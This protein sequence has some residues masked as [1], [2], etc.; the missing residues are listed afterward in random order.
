MKNLTI[1]LVPFEFSFE[2]ITIYYSEGSQEGYDT[3]PKKLLNLDGPDKP[4]ERVYWDLKRFK[5][6]RTA[7]INKENFQIIK[8]ILKK[9][10]REYFLEKK[11]IV[12]SDFIDGIALLEKQNKYSISDLTEYKKFTV[13]IIHPKQ[14]YACNHGSYWNLIISYMGKT[15]ITKKPL[16]HYKDFHDVI[17]KAVVGNTVKHINMLTPE[18]EKS[19]D[20][21]ALVSNKFRIRKTWPK[22]F[23]K[24]PNKYSMFYNEIFAFYENYIKGKEVKINKNDKISIFTS[25][26]QTIRNESIIYTKQDSNLLIF[27]ENRTHFDPYYGIKEHGPH[28]P[29]EQEKYRFF[30]I[31]HQDDRDIA[32]KLYAYF[33]NGIKGFPGLFRFVGLNID[34]FDKEKTIKFKEENPLPEIKQKLESLNFDSSIKYLGIYISRIKKDTDDLDKKGIYYKLKELLLKKNITSQV[35]YRDN[36]MEPSFNYYLPNIGIAVLA[37]FGGIPWRLHRPIESDLI[38]GVGAYRAKQDTYIGT[39]MTFKNDGSFVQFDSSEANSIEDISN[40]LKKI[41]LQISERYENNFKRIIIHYYKTMN[42][43][44]SEIIE[45]TL[46]QLNLKIDEN[47]KIEETLDRL[48]LKIHYIVLHITESESYIPFDN[49]YNGKMPVSGTGVIL[50]DKRHYLLCNN[51]RYSSITRSKIRDFP[52]PVQIKISKTSQEKLS[53][54]DIKLLIDQVY[55]FSRMYWVSVKQKGKPVTIL[56]SEKIAKMS[57]FFDNNTLPDSDTARKTLW[58]L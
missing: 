36:I 1:N 31:F 42:K 32:N 16:S 11:L 39:T 38:I 6:S 8:N 3:I 34:D 43:K 35:I 4:T 23:H 50:N 10:F 53:K 55:Q 46:N 13:R 20:T 56:Y 28:Q 19:D 15:E 26:F 27:G 30:F 22:K 58:F 14:Q 25:G 45:E 41:I 17:K 12:Y 44:E 52:F 24:P 37:K 5:D 33:K 47:E 40:Y 9:S 7:E 48:N 57:S 2:K 51:E 29:I 54:E 21:K 18:E 49:S